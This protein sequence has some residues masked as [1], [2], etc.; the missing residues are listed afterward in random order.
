[1]IIP[2]NVVLPKTPKMMLFVLKNVE[3]ASATVE[4][5]GVEDSNVEE[6]EVAFLQET[7]ATSESLSFCFPTS[8]ERGL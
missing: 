4:G 6:V 7:P 3:L 5:V 2:I 1:M 8:R